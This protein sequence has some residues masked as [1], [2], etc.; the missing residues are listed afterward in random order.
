MPGLY[1]RQEIHGGNGE[2]IV[3][4]TKG[5]EVGAWLQHQP[6]KFKANLLTLQWSKFYFPETE[7]AET[8]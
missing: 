6:V 4:N 7:E 2:A 8:E 3:M 5:V 1:G